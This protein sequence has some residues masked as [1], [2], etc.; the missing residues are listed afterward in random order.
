MVAD[1]EEVKALFSEKHGK[2]RD[3]NKKR[4]STSEMYAQCFLVFRQ[5]LLMGL[6]ALCF[7][8]H[9]TPVARFTVSTVQQ[10][11]L[12]FHPKL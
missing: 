8:P 11:L 5:S 4:P 6:R 7:F 3:T 9:G 1:G 12:E 2:V 10:A